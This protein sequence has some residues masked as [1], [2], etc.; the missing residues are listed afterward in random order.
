VDSSGP[1]SFMLAVL[2][3]SCYVFGYRRSAACAL[4][5]ASLATCINRGISYLPS[6]TISTVNYISDNV[7]M[8]MRF[9]FLDIYIIVIIIIIIIILLLILG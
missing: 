3:S 2:P 9:D 8:H 7:L 6:D 4:S 1:L 5:C